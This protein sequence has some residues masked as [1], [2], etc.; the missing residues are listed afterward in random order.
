MAKRVV[1]K[2]NF[3]KGGVIRA[4]R[5]YVALV[6]Y[7]PNGT[8]FPTIWVEHDPGV[9]PECDYFIVGTGSPIDPYE[10]AEHVGSALC[11]SFVWHVYRS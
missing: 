10:R 6:A 5:G 8:E 1:Y 3:R 11:G 2:Y 4:P 7:Q 9:T